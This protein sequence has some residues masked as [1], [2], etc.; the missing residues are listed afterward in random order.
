MRE[1]AAGN[2]SSGGGGGGGAVSLLAARETERRALRMRRGAEE[3]GAAEE[4][5]EDGEEG[6]AGA[7]WRRFDPAA[8]R[9]DV[10]RAE[11]FLCKQVRS[12]GPNWKP[13]SGVSSSS[14]G[15]GLGPR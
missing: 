3:E 7:E 15:S 5:E 13:L 4:D 11:A 12:L 9:A 6:G 14:G 2:R 10:D 1:A 8:V